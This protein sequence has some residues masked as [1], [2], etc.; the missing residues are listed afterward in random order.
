MIRFDS[1]RRRSIVVGILLCVMAGMD[2]RNAPC[3]WMTPE[4]VKVVIRGKAHRVLHGAIQS[5]GWTE[6]LLRAIGVLASV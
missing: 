4:N 3:Q 2:G 5:N 1:S 6:R